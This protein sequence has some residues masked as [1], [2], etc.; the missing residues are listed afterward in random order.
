MNKISLTKVNNKKV[1]A[2]KLPEDDDRK[3]K[4][5]ELFPEP[6][7]NIFIV[8]KK[9]SGKTS[10]INKILEECV[11]KRTRVVIFCS[12]V[13]KD[14][15][16]LQIMK[17]LK[18]RD[19]SVTP[20]TSIYTRGQDGRKVN[21]VKIIMDALTKESEEKYKDSQNVGKMQGK[22]IRED[23]PEEEDDNE[24][25]KGQKLKNLDWFFV[26]DDL[27]NELRDPVIEEFI[28]KNRH[29]NS[30]MIYSSQAYIDLNPSER[31]N[32]EYF[33]LYP[34]IPADKLATI[35]QD[36]GTS[37]DLED[38][39]RMYYT[40]TDE[41]Y[42]FLYVDRSADEKIRKNFDEEFKTSE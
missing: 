15:N 40:A 17:R 33:L 11:G 9:R 1:T 30:K 27:S 14:K 23:D 4:G 35:H 32:M 41:P 26:F 7:A 5:H 19:I 38:F 8:G 31:T 12:T 20:F 16:W 22:G 24:P 2:I 37:L 13:F 29:F 21:R 25:D 18:E 10:S 3:Y 28:K 36:S 42:N 6:H 39:Y 34:K